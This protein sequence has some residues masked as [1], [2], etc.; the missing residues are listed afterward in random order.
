LRILVAQ[1]KR[2]SESLTLKNAAL[3][4]ENMRLQ[5]ANTELRTE[6]VDVDA[7]RIQ[8]LRGTKD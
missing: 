4:I 3:E 7:L 2:D 5:G 1:L 6:L 8:L